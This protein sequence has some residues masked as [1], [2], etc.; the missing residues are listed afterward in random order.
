MKKLEY[1]CSTTKLN[2]RQIRSI[3]TIKEW[4]EIEGYQ[5]R[6]RQINESIKLDKLQKYGETPKE[7]VDF[8][9]NHLIECNDCKKEYGKTKGT[10]T[11]FSTIFGK[12]KKY[13]KPLTTQNN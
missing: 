4:M 1:I 12:D 7:I 6:K 13:L 2:G 11:F 3:G 5:A 9:N 8:F 10:T